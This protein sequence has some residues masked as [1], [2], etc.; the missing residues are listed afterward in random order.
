MRYRK[1]VNLGTNALA[2][3]ASH[4]FRPSSAPRL[5]GRPRSS[6]RKRPIL[7]RPRAR[8]RPLAACCE[9]PA[10]VN[11][12]DPAEY[13]RDRALWSKCAKSDLLQFFADFEEFQA[14]G[15]NFTPQEVHQAVLEA[16]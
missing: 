12:Y 10:L 6:A 9:S 1:A 4:G 14:E 2:F 5:R 16:L 11:A 7:C 3:F 8:L 15:H 13:Y